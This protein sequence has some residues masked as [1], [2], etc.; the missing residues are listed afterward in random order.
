MAHEK[1]TGL[2]DNKEADGSTTNTGDATLSNDVDVERQ[3]GDQSGSTT[4]SKDPNIVGWEVDDPENPLN[5]HTW[6]KVGVVVVV[7][8]ITMLS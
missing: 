6:K 1:S 7:A 8:F 4:A 5:W 2:Y 3:S